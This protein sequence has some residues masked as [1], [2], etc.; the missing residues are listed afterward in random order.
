MWG[1]CMPEKKSPDLPFL[2]QANLNHSVRAYLGQAR[3]RVY[4]LFSGIPPLEKK[5]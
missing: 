1:L 4:I 5:T 2:K 3:V